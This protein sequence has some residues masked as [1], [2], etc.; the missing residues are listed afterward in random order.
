MPAQIIHAPDASPFGEAF[1]R[2]RAE[3]AVPASFPPEVEA[4]AE[5]VVTR[6]PLVPGG[7][8]QTRVDGRDIPFVTIDPLGSLDLDQAYHAERQGRGFRVRY[9][10]ADVAAFVAPGSALDRESFARGVTLYL[11][12]GRAPM[13]PNQLGEGAASLLPDDDRAALLWTIDLDETGASTAARLERATVRSRAKL[14]YGGVQS[15]LDAGRA[16]EPLVLLREIGT[17]R[18]AL[19][20]ARGGVSLDLP[21]RK[22]VV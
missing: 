4:E 18:L 6:G 8:A 5:A 10:I 19:E 15:A 22:S 2:I 7:G 11:P 9:A 16:D 1:A 12:D 14:D 17:L 13:V 21:D 20:A 3:F